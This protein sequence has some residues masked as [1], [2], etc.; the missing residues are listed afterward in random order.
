MISVGEYHGQIYVS[1]GDHL[2]GRS[3]NGLKCVTMEDEDQLGG[4]YLEWENE[5]PGEKWQNKCTHAAIS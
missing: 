1:E 3:K 2:S 4:C 5:G